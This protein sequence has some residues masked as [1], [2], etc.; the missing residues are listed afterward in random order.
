VLKTYTGKLGVRPVAA[1]TDR[2][3]SC[4]PTQ[5]YGSLVLMCPSCTRVFTSDLPF[6]LVSICVPLVVLQLCTHEPNIRLTHFPPPVQGKRLILGGKCPMAAVQIRATPL[7]DQSCLVSKYLVILNFERDS[8]G[9]EGKA[10][11]T[12]LLEHIR[13]LCVCVWC[14]RKSVVCVFLSIASDIST[15]SANVILR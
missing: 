8:A 9:N 2:E 13:S 6:A 3:C 4:N 15:Y 11:D 7:E 5:L 12:W 1:A 10:T 14:T